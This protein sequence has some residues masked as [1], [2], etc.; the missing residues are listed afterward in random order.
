[1]KKIP[2]LRTCGTGIVDEFGAPVRL[3]GVNLGS[4]LLMEGYILGGRNVPEQSFRSEFEK[5][6]GRK[7]MEEFTLSFRDSFITE[8]D[9]RSIK[10]WG[11]NC[12]RIPFNYR[13]VEREERPRRINKEGISY[14]DKAVN[15]CGKFGIYCILDLHAAP[16]AQNPD[17]HSDC[18]GRHELFAKDKNMDRY[19]RIWGIL[20]DRYKGMSAVA[21]YDI[22]NEPVIEISKEKTL[23]NLYER[24][25]REIRRYDTKHIIFLEGNM[26]SR[27]LGFIGRPDDR[28]T[29]LSVHAYI[30]G[31]YLFNFERD[32][33]YPGIVSGSMW[34]ASQIEKAA[35]PYRMLAEKVGMPMYVGEFGVNWRGGYYGELEWASDIIRMFEKFGWSWTY[36]TYKSVANSIHPDGIYRYVD[37]PP[38]VNRNGPLCGPETFSSCWPKF[39]NRMVASW[40]TKNF[41][42]NE[43]LLAALEK[44]F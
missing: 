27:R 18:L 13:I 22:L 37:N 34:S 15:W 19:V 8:E 23:K 35:T 14:L 10:R 20:A 21:G 40:R 4:W 43:K 31:D 29:A 28:N 7:A 36:W 17:W 42:K 5:R 25:I 32:L 41:V 12:V 26:F 16:G 6:L 30:P 1:M 9:I 38:W 33:R 44:F 3:R 39:K 2:L 11:A 24:V